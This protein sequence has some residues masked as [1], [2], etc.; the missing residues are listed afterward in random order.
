MKNLC[1]KTLFFLEIELPEDFQV[2]VKPQKI[3][4]KI[5]INRTK[6]KNITKKI[7]FIKKYHL[8]LKILELLLFF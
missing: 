8:S 6:L 4:W 7:N 2:T 5:L 1:M 3:F